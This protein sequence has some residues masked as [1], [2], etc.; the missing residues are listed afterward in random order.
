MGRGDSVR[1]VVSDAQALPEAF[2]IRGAREAWYCRLAIDAPDTNENLAATFVVLVR[3][4]G[5]TSVT[6][7][8]DA[9]SRALRS[10][11]WRRLTAGGDCDPRV[12]AHV[13]RVIALAYPQTVQMLRRKLAGPQP[14][15]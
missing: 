10:V 2:K 15:E 11:E 9:Q 5:I 13:M 8:S 7:I 6:D 12:A 14:Q 4:S 1:C 3:R